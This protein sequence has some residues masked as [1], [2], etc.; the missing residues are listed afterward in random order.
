MTDLL[1]ENRLTKLSLLTVY[2][3]LERLGFKTHEKGLL[4]QQPREA[5]NGCI[6]LTFHQTVMQLEE[7]MFRWIQ[8]PLEQ[9]EEM[10]Q[11]K[12]IEEGLGYWYEDMVEFHINEHPFFQDRMSTTDYRGNLSIRKPADVKVP[13]GI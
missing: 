11:N 10:E 1:R 5:G 9:V 3:W 13:C 7:R 2:R 4:C 6:L 12:E 8:L